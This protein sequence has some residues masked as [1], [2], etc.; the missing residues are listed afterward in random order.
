MVLGRTGRPL[1]RQGDVPYPS[2]GDVLLQAGDILL[3]LTDG[4]EEAIRSD[5]EIFGMERAVEV[6]RSHRDLPASEI[7][8]AVC[9]AARTFS[10][11]EPQ[12]D[13][14]TVVVLKAL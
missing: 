2:G 14:L 9:T 8:E 13:D 11:P 7:V 5:D 3:L 6:V 1:G 4:I 10:S 12:T